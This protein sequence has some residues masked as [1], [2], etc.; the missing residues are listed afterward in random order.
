MIA[1]HSP[2]INITMPLAE[3]LIVRDNCNSEIARVG[4]AVADVFDILVLCEL[5][6]ELKFPGKIF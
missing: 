5:T 3:E 2:Y 6:V 4:S 1:E